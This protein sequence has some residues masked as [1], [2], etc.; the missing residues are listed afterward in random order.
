MK[1]KSI[2]TF[3]VLS[4]I[5]ISC[6]KENDIGIQIDGNGRPRSVTKAASVSG[7][8]INNTTAKDSTILGEYGIAIDPDGNPRH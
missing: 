5:L 7:T 1:R 2:L 6:K 4:L 3:I 8:E